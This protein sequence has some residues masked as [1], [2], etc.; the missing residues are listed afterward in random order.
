[1]RVSH[2]IQF[3]F[4]LKMRSLSSQDERSYEKH[5]ENTIDH[6]TMRQER[7]NCRYGR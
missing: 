4:H 3:T 6:S 1:M 7:R 2:R 5:A